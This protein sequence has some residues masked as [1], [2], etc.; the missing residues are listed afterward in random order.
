[1]HPMLSVSDMKLGMKLCSKL[2]II[3]CV[4]NFVCQI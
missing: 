2:S 4:N 1:M 3:L